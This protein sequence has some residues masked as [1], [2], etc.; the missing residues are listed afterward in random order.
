MK[1][2]YRLSVPAETRDVNLAT[3]ARQVETWLDGLPNSDVLDKAALL[4]DYL[5]E[6][7]RPDLPAGF[8]TQ[9]LDLTGPAV[10]QVLQALA[11]K[12]RDLPVPLNEGLRHRLDLA[13]RLLSSVAAVN[14][15]LILEQAEHPPGLFGGNPLPGPIARFLQAAGR[16]LELCYLCHCQVPEGLWLDLHQ[17]GYLILQAGLA[18]STDPVNPSFKLAGSYV[19]L[20]LEAVAD[21]YHF[22]EQERSWIR[23]LIVQ[24]G[25]LARIEDARS[26]RL[27]GV[28]GIRVSEDKAPYQLSRQM[29]MVPDCELVLSTAPLAKRLA[30]IINHMEQG[31][32][33]ELVAKLVRDPAYMA[34]LQ[35]LKLLWS[36]YMLRTSPRRTH[37]APSRYRMLLSFQAI[38][39]HL[40]GGRNSSQEGL[41]VSAQLANESLG[42]LAISAVT[43]AFHLKTGMLVYLSQGQ[44]GGDFRDLGVVRWFKTRA[45][46][47]LTVGIKLLVGQPHPVTV[48]ARDGWHVYPGLILDQAR[49][50][51]E[52]DV[53]PDQVRLI[54]P[55][56]RL[57]ANFSVVIRQ[58]TERSR[59]HLSEILEGSTDIALFRA[60]PEGKE[61]A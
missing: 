30:L 1:P 6:H 19:A 47:V 42:G 11:V 36:G 27:K 40:A 60:Y 38:Y 26:A 21:P 12:F 8:R 29:E 5:T 46:G 50:R 31:K 49:H 53:L 44:E 45:D 28:Y 33:V 35:Q 9:L 15:R 37:P 4:A 20:L 48:F 54:M 16:I 57:E 34:L 39:R 24:F 32:A 23:G 51:G 52:Q 55:A 14:K 13:I 3:K 18:D 61:P 25:H 17:T 22:S 7:D 56:V 2:S 58:E 41:A 59:L 43:P 10:D